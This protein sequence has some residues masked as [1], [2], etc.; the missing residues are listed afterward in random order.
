MSPPLC[1]NGLRIKIELPGYQ[2]YIF[3]YVL[4]DEVSA[5][6]VMPL[7]EASLATDGLFVFR[8]DA[9]QLK[10]R[11]AGETAKIKGKAVKADE[12]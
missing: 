7:L 12:K 3:A 1:R 2:N 8:R 11:L 6:K 9:E 10:S 4:A 5:D